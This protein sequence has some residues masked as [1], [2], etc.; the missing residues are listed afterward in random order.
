M[1][2][3][4]SIVS[5]PV[6]SPVEHPETIET[7]TPSRDIALKHRLSISGLKWKGGRRDVYFRA[8][9]REDCTGIHAATSGGALMESAPRRRP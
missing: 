9:K 6:V 1:S 7:T 2:R 4:V 3:D 5:Q 8:H